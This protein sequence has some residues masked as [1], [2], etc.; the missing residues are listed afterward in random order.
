M[1]RTRVGVYVRAS[2]KSVHNL[3]SE[4]TIGCGRGAERQDAKAQRRT[5]GSSGG[6]DHGRH[7]NALRLYAFASLR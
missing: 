7:F 1:K 6:V 5:G 4:L 3:A 2:E